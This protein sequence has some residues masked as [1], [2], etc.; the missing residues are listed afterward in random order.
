MFMT[1]DWQATSPVWIYSWKET[2]FNRKF[3]ITNRMDNAT[4][5]KIRERSVS[6]F[7]IG[8]EERTGLRVLLLRIAENLL[9][10]LD[11]FEVG[12]LVFVLGFALPGQFWGTGLGFG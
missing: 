1:G 7:F 10:S 12:I 8:S 9:G 11:R 3:S 2:E 6:R 5:R 4:V